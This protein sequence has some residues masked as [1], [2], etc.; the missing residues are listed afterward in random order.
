MRLK[1]QLFVAVLIAQLSTSA[2]AA[3]SGVEDLLPIP[4]TESLSICAPQRNG[5]ATREQVVN[6]YYAKEWGSTNLV[7]RPDTRIAI[8]AVADAVMFGRFYIVR[9][10]I[11]SPSAGWYS[12][13]ERIHP[14]SDMGGKGGVLSI[15]KL[16]TGRLDASDIA[17]IARAIEQ[18]S[19]WKF[20]HR[21][22]ESC[23]DGEPWTVEVIE[24]G[25]HNI[26]DQNLACDSKTGLGILGAAIE[27]MLST[28]HLPKR[29]KEF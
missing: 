3:N 15:G 19:F 10:E 12:V 11:T 8:R 20:D 1:C 24:S 13:Q 28:K 6:C 23:M 14:D 22:G 4:K 7:T 2:Q 17:G 29:L 9:I 27:N 26:V 25:Q 16:H 21:M 5:E 18:P